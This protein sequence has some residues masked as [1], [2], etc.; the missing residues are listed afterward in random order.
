[1]GLKENIK[2]FRQRCNLTL[3]EVS[4]KLEVSKP[5]LQR[6]E[7]GVI[8]NIPSDKVERLAEI[9][10]ITPSELMGW[11]KIEKR[12][13]KD[14]AFDKYLESIDYSIKYH[15][16]VLEWHNEDV[17]KDGKV[18]GQVQVSDKE[19]FTVTITKNEI[20]TTMTEDEFEDFRN[21]IEKSV[22]FEIF[23]ASQK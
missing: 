1:M 11:D 23:K 8:S 10:G 15:Q 7:S 9:F 14:L 19:T 5:T 16:E 6:Y 13:S 12:I 17:I 3:E 18:I 21:T 4:Q 2:F 20:S 22:E